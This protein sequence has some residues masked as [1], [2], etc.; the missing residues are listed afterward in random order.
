MRN[1]KRGA[2]YRWA[3]QLEVANVRADQL[4]EFE[5]EGLD[6]AEALAEDAAERSTDAVTGARLVPSEF[7]LT[8]ADVAHARAI[9]PAYAG[10]AIAA[11]RRR[12]F[13]DISDRAIRA[14]VER[15]RAK[16][17]RRCGGPRPCE[18]CGEPLPVES[19]PNMRC[20][21]A[22]CRDLKRRASHR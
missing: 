22:R 20:H 4:S 19:R 13:G 6:Y 7:G 14:R 18:G 17:A 11:A 8:I 2:S 1:E 12:L 9:T 10:R 3:L 16:A 21:D 15:T 5:W